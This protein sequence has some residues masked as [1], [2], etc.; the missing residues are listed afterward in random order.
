MQYSSTLLFNEDNTT[1]DAGVFIYESCCS[2][3]AFVVAVFQDSGCHL[4]FP[5]I[6]CMNDVIHVSF[7]TFHDRTTTSKSDP[8]VSYCSW[9]R[10]EN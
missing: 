3:H 6:S 1:T 4:V 5:Y 9:P 10:T 8:D 7:L 2:Y